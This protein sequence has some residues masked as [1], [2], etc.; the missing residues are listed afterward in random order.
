MSN[1]HRQIFKSTALIGGAQVINI[2]L[3]IVRTK[4]LAIL[5]GPSGMGI[6]GLYQ[7]ATGLI[8]TLAG[9]GIGSAGV[10]QIAEAAGTG[11]ED[12]IAGTV[13]TLRLT[14]L[15]SGLVGMIVILLFCRRIGYTT[16]G[17]DSYTFGIALMSL[18][19][20]FGGISAGQWALL[21]G[22]RRLKDLA[23]CEVIGV[24]FGT[25]AST[26]LVYF[27]RERGIAPYLVAVSGFG[28]LSSW[29][30]ARKVRVKAVKITVREI[31][32]DSKGLLNMGLA[33][34]VSGLLVSGVAYLT[35]VLISR[36]LGM[37][38][39]GLYS[40]VWTLSTLYVGVILNAMG[41]DFYPRLTAVS[42]DNAAVNQLVNEQT[43]MG[44]LIAIPGILATLTLAP[45]V[46]RAFYSEAFMPAADVIRWQILGI[47]LR[48]VSWPM[49]FVQLGKGM[50]KL[51]MLT[52]TVFAAVNVALLFVCMKFWG[53]E[54]VGI[55]FMFHYIL[56]TITMLAVC[57]RISGFAWTR[58]LL[59]FILAACCIISIIMLAIR[60][61]PFQQGTLCGLVITG[62]TLAA[63]CFGLQQLLDLNIKS[64][65]LKLRN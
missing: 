56:Y 6:A 63:C 34:M 26:T 31:A 24:L 1:S 11:D 18:T 59:L 43:E 62:L 28:I 30:Y 48:V 41:A 39:V 25:I 5:L 17:N 3:G 2:L 38:A 27:L 20:L 19:V 58:R 42:S 54:G 16:F 60:N 29:W 55:S 52:E 15:L 9:F 61:L 21:Q 46:L 37:D 44:I 12:R 4:V 40:A 22:M 33:F 49:G 14:S 10:R 47:A 7:S 64:L 57:R 36:Q 32:K 35:R 53:L 45:W 13:R 51:F 23:A 50:S 65:I 8:G